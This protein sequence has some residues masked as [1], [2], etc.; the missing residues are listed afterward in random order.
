METPESQDAISHSRRQ[1]V[2]KTLAPGVSASLLGMVLPQ[3]LCDF[4]Y[5]LPRQ[6]VTLKYTP[7]ATERTTC[8]HSS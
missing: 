3:A 1:S 5:L 4:R 7:T 8:L 2:D 6:G